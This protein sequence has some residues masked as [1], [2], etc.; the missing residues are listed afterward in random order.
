[1]KLTIDTQKKSCTISDEEGERELPLYSNEAFAEIAKCYVNVGWNQRY[2][3]TFSWMGRP[4]I[5]MPEDMVRIQEI[6]HR[7]KPD[8]II[9]TGVAHGGS[10]IFY[11]TLCEALHHG[12]IVGI[13]IDIRP[14]NR[15]A[16][17]AHPL[18]GRI[19]LIQGSSIAPEVVDT[20]KDIIQGAKSVLVILDSN[21]SYDH[22]MRELQ[23]YAP[24]VTVGS[25]IVAT[26][27]VMEQLWDVPLG[28]AE[29]RTDNPSRAARDFAASN[30]DFKIGQPK[31][32]F[33]ESALPGTG[34]A[35]HWPDA[36][37]QRI[38]K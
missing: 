22:V 20:V 3:Y 28:H 6:I 19:S 16:I 21:H 23:L 10:L 24:M 11:A 34:L 25:Y 13:D 14:D 7:T 36:Y 9:E 26:D 32:V 27:G 17:E 2:S 38:S 12:R 1:M 37:L 8:F 5:Q 29:W 30:P 35:T 18:S 15:A 31:R 33:D 4:I